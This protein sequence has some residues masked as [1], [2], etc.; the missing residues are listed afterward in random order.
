MSDA[1]FVVL[2]ITLGSLASWLASNI[3]EVRKSVES[4]QTIVA[5]TN[6]EDLIKKAMLEALEEHDDP[7]PL[8]QPFEEGYEERLKAW[9]ERHG[10]A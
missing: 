1:M 7:R 3:G 4:L 6:L 10:R 2:L 9:K 5:N 8:P